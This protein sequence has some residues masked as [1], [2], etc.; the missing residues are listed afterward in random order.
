MMKIGKTSHKALKTTL[1][2]GIS[3]T[4]LDII[5]V[6]SILSVLS[7]SIIIHNPSNPFDVQDM[8]TLTSSVPAGVI[9]QLTNLIAKIIQRVFFPLVLVIAAIVFMF[10]RK[11]NFTDYSPYKPPIKYQRLV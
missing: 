6:L 11:R 1:D 2:R 8:Y 9:Y 7:V 10:I 3:V 5:F 4:P